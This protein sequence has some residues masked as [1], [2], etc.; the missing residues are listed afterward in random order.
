MSKALARMSPTERKAVTAYYVEHKAPD[1]IELE[2]GIEADAFRKLISSIRFRYKDSHVKIEELI[3]Q[4][5]D[6]RKHL[7]K[8]ITELNRDK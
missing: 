1:E 7:T 4:L 6:Q 2:F 8:L 5:R 3:Q